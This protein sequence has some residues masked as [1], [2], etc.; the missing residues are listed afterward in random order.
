[1]APRVPRANSRLP[2]ALTHFA[3]EH[4]NRHVGAHLSLSHG[5][6]LE[7]TSKLKALG[8]SNKAA[9]HTRFLQKCIKKSCTL[10][11]RPLEHCWPL[12]NCYLAKCGH[13]GSSLWPQWRCAWK[14]SSLCVPHFKVTQRHRNRHGSI[15]YLWLPISDS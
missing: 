7:Y 1:M 3:L 14:N 12:E 8:H 11:L 2:V 4:R 6:P 9:D 10:R 5:W 15:S 13:I